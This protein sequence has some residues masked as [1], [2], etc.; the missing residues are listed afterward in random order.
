MRKEIV[1]LTSLRGIAAMA[2]IA[3]HY[4]ATMQPLASGKFPA[5]AP[6]GNLAVDVFFV[7][8]GF[9]MG[10]TYL[11]SFRELDGS[12]AY[13]EFLIKRVARILPLNAAMA[14]ILTAAAFVS[15][16]LFGAN[17]FP[18][19]PQHGALFNWIANALMLPG[20]GIGQSINWPAWSISVEFAA[21]FLFPVFLACIFS[22]SRPIFL[23]TCF[24]A[25]AGIVAVCATGNHLSPDGIHSHHFLPWR[26]LGRCFSEFV[27]GLVTF[28]F[29]ASGKFRKI[30]QQDST[31]FAIVIV[32]AVIIALKLGDLFAVLLF[33]PLVLCLSVNNGL[34]ARAMSLRFPY[35][36]GVISYSLYLVHD[37]F[38]PIAAAIV[39]AIHPQPLA[40]LM[41]MAFAALFSLM[42]IFPAWVCYRWIERPGRAFFRT[43]IPVALSARTTSS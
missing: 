43:F 1:P 22:R 39:H 42:M 3:E 12:T 38:R 37:N 34:V 16:W 2:V 20:L 5:L 10:Y 30:L 14:T 19:V 4:S 28:R 7:L 8:S 31:V 21:Y 36:L 6:H 41:A 17:Q 32:I 13:R 23:A 33:P 27:L 29:W 40:P 24:T 11:P 9:I 26:D 35:F 18:K 25:V 15:V